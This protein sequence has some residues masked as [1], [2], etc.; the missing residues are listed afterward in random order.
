MPQPV[1]TLASSNHNSFQPEKSPAAPGHVE[2]KGEG[3]VAKGEFLKV[4]G[5]C[6]VVRAKPAPP[7][8][9]ALEF[10]TCFSVN[11]STV[12]RWIAEGTIP[13]KYVEPVGQR[14]LL[15][16]A[17]AVPECAARFRALRGLSVE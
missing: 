16:L 3:P 14:K 7:K 17:K 13:A 5:Q 11:R 8:L 15:I 12:Y 6:S 10:A 9:T 2:A 4:G 1:V